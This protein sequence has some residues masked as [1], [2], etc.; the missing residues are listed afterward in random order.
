MLPTKLEYVLPLVQ[1]KNSRRE[2]SRDERR[3][4]QEMR[5]YYARGE[6]K[7]EEGRKRKEMRQEEGRRRNEMR[8]EKTEEKK[9]EEKG[10]E[11]RRRETRTVLSSQEV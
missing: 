2:G 7:G 9:G 10:R 5:E 8:W 4:G 3:R 11:G 1:K 6:E